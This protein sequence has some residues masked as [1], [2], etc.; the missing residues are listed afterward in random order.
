MSKEDIFSYS[1][2]SN[3]AK[4]YGALTEELLSRLEK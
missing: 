1:S 2:E 3:G 4:D